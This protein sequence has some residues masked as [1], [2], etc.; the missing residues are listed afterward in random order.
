MGHP[1]LGAAQVIWADLTG[2]GAKE[3]GRYSGTA[4]RELKARRLLGG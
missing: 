1:P 2:D 4:H 3:L